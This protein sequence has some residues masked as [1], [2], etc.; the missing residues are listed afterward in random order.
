MVAVLLPGIVQYLSDR[1]NMLAG[2]PMGYDLG[3]DEIHVWL[4]RAQWPSTSIRAV[5]EILSPEEQRKA[6]QFKFSQDGERHMIGRGLVRCLLGQLLYIRPSVLRFCYNAFGKPSICAAQNRRDLQ[7][8]ISHSGDLIM[9]ALAVGCQIGVDV[10]R[11]REDLEIEGIAK[12]FLSTREQANLAALSSDQRRLGFFRCWTRKEAFI[13]ARGEGLSLPGHLFDVTLNPAEPAELLA[14]RPDSSE[15][16]RWVI[17]D[18]DAGVHYMAAI[19]K[20]GRGGPL[21]TMEW[22]P[23][24]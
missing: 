21:H 6:Q 7:F 22:H 12:Y 4:T 9:V 3:R 14:T 13:K 11:V 23:G 24:S 1:C 20:E 19:A 17:R 8:N 2:L 18:V 10:E 16:S 5:A 15:V